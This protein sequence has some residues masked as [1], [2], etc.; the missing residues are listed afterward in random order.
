M[1]DRDLLRALLQ[2]L[3]VYFDN[4]AAGTR[5]KFLAGLR[6]ILDRCDD[7]PDPEKE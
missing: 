5:E 2:L 7:A 6:Q 1:R 4:P 3:A